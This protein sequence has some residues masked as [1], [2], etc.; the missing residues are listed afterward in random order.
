[1]GVDRAVD[2]VRES[3]FAGLAE[4]GDYF[5][6]VYPRR[7]GESRV[8]ILDRALTLGPLT[9]SILIHGF[10]APGHANEKLAIAL[11]DR[12]GLNEPLLLEKIPDRAAFSINALRLRVWLHQSKTFAPF[13]VHP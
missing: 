4:F 7:C 8:D 11:D 6:D 2:V 9:Q 10:E 12:I 3:A 5:V 13:A 1:M